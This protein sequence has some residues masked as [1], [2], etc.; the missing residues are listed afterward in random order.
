VA[1]SRPSSTSKPEIQNLKK[2]GVEIRSLDLANDAQEAIVKALSGVQVLLSCVGPMAQM[3]QIPLATAAKTAGVQRFVPCGYLTVMPVGVH[4]L[5]DMKEEVYNHIKRLGLLY[6]IIDC[7]WWYQISL[8]GLPSG[9]IDYAIGPDFPV[10]GDGNQGSA[11]TDVRDVGRYVARVIED[12][13]TLNKQVM[14]F[15]EVWTMNQVSEALEKASGE[16]PMR[17]RM[18]VE[19]L[20]KTIAE[21]QEKV[22]TD[23]QNYSLMVRIVG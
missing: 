5:R 13:R 19:E 17:E 1:Y 8:P 9:K 23:P 7:G 10:A 12:E 3:D 16:K 20:E 2:S 15:N 18:S 4:M 14:V 21:A 6:T 22:Q 11:L